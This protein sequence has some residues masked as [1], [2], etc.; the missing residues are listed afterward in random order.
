M[1]M[2]IVMVTKHRDKHNIYWEGGGA[3]NL[4]LIIREII[5]SDNYC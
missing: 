3:E 1:M 4:N 2:I 5:L